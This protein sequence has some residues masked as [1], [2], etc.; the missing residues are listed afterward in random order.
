[1]HLLVAWVSVTIYILI[2]VEVSPIFITIIL[3]HENFKVIRKAVMLENKH[4]T[5]EERKIPN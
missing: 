2:Q 1:M 5:I 4:T 3:N